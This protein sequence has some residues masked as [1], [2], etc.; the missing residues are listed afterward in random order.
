MREDLKEKQCKSSSQCHLERHHVAASLV[1][2]LLVHKNVKGAVQ[3]V[4]FNHAAG[5]TA[6]END[7]NIIKL[8]V[9]L[10]RQSIKLFA[11]TPV[12]DFRAGRARFDISAEFFQ[13][14]NF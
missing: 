13:K 3:M 2:G 12:T 6:E 8:D 11:S 9:S 7:E 5:K 14:I 4:T 1:P 10:N